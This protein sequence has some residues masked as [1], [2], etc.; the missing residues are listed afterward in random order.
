MDLLLLALRIALAGVLLTASVGKLLDLRNPAGRE[1][2]EA[3]GI[4]SGLAPAAAIALPIV[5]LLLGILLLPVATAWWAALGTLL[6]MFLFM[7][8]IARQMAQGN[9]PDCHCFG[10][11]HSA[12]AGPSTLARNGVF[13]A[14]AAI[15]VAFGW[16]DPGISIGG[17]FADRSGVELALLAV[18]VVGLAAIA[19][20]VWTILQ[21]MGQAGRMLNRIEAL[22]GAMGIDPDGATAPAAETPRREAGTLAVGSIAP[23]FSL[24][25]LAGQTVSLAS[26]RQDGVPLMLVFTSPSCTPCTRLMPD[27]A[28]WQRDHA[29]RLRPVVVANGDRD[30]NAAKASET[31]VSGILL[32]PDREV[33]GAYGSSSTPSAIVVLP[34]GTIGSALAR[35]ATAVR[36]LVDAQ[37]ATPFVP[38]APPAATPG[39][40]LTPAPAIDLPALDGPQTTLSTLGVGSRPVVLVFTDPHCDPC[41]ELLP[42]LLA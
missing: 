4:P 9:A 36:A 27:I 13:A 40:T 14:M 6:L 5:E 31:G 26:L 17:W 28:R 25:D 33:S 15:I 12:P 29:Q 24:P 2:M 19:F 32:Q 20:L 30:A 42:D 22:E 35:G 38:A 3:F 16:N 21:L 10:Q 7:A 34:D 18:S 1:A 37:V 8:G 23:D 11:L 41:A 39:P